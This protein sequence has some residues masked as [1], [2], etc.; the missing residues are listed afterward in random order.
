VKTRGTFIAATL[1]TLVAAALVLVLSLSAP[2]SAASTKAKAGVVARQFMHSL[3]AKRF[4]RTCRLMSTRF[5]RENHVPSR[6]RCVLGLRV[7]FMG[8]PE[9]RFK[10]LGVRVQG[11]E[12]VVRGLANG[13]PGKIVLVEENHLLKVLSLRGA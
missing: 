7:G 12:V 3:N 11:D 13:A 1:V 2:S 8:A 10:I 9:V 4:E 6:E 5:Y